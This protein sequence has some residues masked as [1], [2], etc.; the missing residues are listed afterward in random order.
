[1]PCAFGHMIRNMQIRSKL[2]VVLV[3]PLVAAVSE[4]K[5]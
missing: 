3:I 4:A 5:V 2:I 1:M